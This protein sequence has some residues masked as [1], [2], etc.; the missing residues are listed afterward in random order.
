MYS[1]CR[2]VPDSRKQ[3]A[4]DAEPSLKN[5]KTYPISLKA[6][7]MST[8]WTSIVRRGIVATGLACFT[9]SIA[10][11]PSR[12]HATDGLPLEMIAEL[13]SPR[14]AGFEKEQGARESDQTRLVSHTYAE[15]LYEGESG[16]C[17]DC[18]S[19]SAN[20]GCSSS[21]SKSS[22]G[23]LGGGLRKKAKSLCGSKGCP[24][25][26]WAH[27]TGV[28]GEF[29]YLTAGSSD[30]IHAIESAVA[31][32]APIEP[33]GPVGIV[34]MEAQ[35]GYRAG[36]TLASSPCSSLNLIFT[37]WDGDAADLFEADDAQ[38]FVAISQVLHPVL[39]NA[40]VQ[41]IVSN[42]THEMS[43]QNVDVN[44][45]HIWKQTQCT[46]INWTAGLRYGG[47][48]Q[49]FVGNQLDGAANGLARVT[50]DIDFEGFGISGGLDL[51]RY[52]CK[53]GLFIYGK[54]LASL[55]AGDWEAT[56]RHE[57]LQIGGGVIANAYEDFHATPTLEGEIGLGWMNPGGHIRLQTGMM[58]SG[59]YESVST[60][61]YIDAV[62]NGN[63]IDIGET[64]TFSGLTTRLSILF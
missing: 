60:R 18:G 27:R 39:D 42:A 12:A 49:D 45:R 63:L 10:F 9:A 64:I 11:L 31:A 15:S 48:E 47:M 46:V 1:P 52:S 16:W 44:Y 17:S 14:T 56:Y 20:C 21:Q 37:R 3:D 13:E 23:I 41:S 59:W 25:P 40:G 54:G 53:T 30:I 2:G 58:M 24:Q 5:F 19:G 22:R 55:M 6:V 57:N 36:L 33:T 35:P 8:D 29:L 51:E 38:N 7:T 28:F 61:G 43:F 32:P 34:D 26:W 50:T 4:D 62:R